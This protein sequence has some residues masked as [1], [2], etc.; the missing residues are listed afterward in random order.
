MLNPPRITRVRIP[1]ETSDIAVANLDAFYDADR[2]YVVRQYDEEGHNVT[3]TWVLVHGDFQL[4]G[5]D[6]DDPADLDAAASIRQRILSS[7]D[8]ESRLHGSPEIIS[9]DNVWCRDRA[10]GALAKQG[11]SSEITVRDWTSSIG[12]QCLPAAR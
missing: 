8:F 5:T 1:I 11:F 7:I 12:P 2:N 3:R 4:A 9:E 6:I 10:C